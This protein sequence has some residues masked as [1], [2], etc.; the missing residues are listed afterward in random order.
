MFITTKFDIDIEEQ[1]IKTSIW[2]SESGLNQRK[3]FT[4]NESKKYL[5]SPN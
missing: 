1:E 3:Q 5:E 4:I 2:F